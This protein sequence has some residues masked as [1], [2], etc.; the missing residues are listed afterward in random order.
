MSASMSP[1]MNQDIA[2]I[3]SL[4]TGTIDAYI[5]SAYQIP[6]LTAEEERSLAERYRGACA[7][8]WPGAGWHRWSSSPAPP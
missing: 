5:S 7:A 3:G 4:S 8:F 2:T 6:V 1:T